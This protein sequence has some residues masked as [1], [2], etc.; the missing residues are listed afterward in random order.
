MLLSSNL[1]QSLLH[2]AT[3]HK[4]YLFRAGVGNKRLFS[5]HSAARE[6]NLEVFS[7]SVIWLCMFFFFLTSKLEDYCDRA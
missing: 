4:E 6:D 7:W 1:L 3:K 5:P 2:I